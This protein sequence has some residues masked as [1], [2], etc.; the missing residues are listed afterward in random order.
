[1]AKDAKDAPLPLYVFAGQKEE[2]EA[3]KIGPLLL[4]SPT[5][6]VWNCPGCV[7]MPNTK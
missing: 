4:S 5:G 1:M 2:R 6:A 7:C 3:E